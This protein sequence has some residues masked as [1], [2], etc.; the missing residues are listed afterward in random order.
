MTERRTEDRAQTTLDFAIG[1]SVFLLTVAFAF[2]FVPSMTAPFVDGSQ[3]DTATADRV[4]SHL[5]EGQLADPDDPYVL[6]ETCTQ[7]FFENNTA[8]DHCAF[9]ED[10]GF[11]ERIGVD[12]GANVN[13][14]L[15]RATYVGGDRQYDV[16]YGIGD[17]PENADSIV[18]ARRV[19]SHD[20]QDKTLFVRVW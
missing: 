13:V 6:N 2:T 12:D 8:P 17:D 14:T 16:E 7:K 9:E 20:G 15:E 5:A 3:P 1:M 19:V 4:A 11:R 10:P 18:V